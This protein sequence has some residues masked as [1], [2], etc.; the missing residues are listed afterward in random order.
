MAQTLAN[1]QIQIEAGD[2]LYD[3]YG[4][5]WRQLSGY[6]G[7]PTKLQIGTVLNSPTQ[8][9]NPVTPTTSSNGT[10]TPPKSNADI[11]KEIDAKNIELAIKQQQLLDNQTLDSMGITQST[12]DALGQQ[13]IA[14]MAAIGTAIQSQYEAGKTVPQI[15]TKEDLDRIFT[16]AQNDPIIDK[17]YKEQ[18]TLGKNDFLMA[19][20]YLKAGYEEER[21]L[22]ADKQTLEKETLANTEAESGRAYSGFRQQAESRLSA[23]QQGLIESTRRSSKYK[24]QGIGSA[25]EKQYGT[26]ALNQVNP[27]MNDIAYNPQ[28]NIAG[29]TEADRLDS[30]R[31]REQSIRSDTLLTRGLLK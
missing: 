8:S 14:T 3:I 24:M 11:Q 4:S 12:K 7:D 21:R 13:G 20:E 6:T 25:F 1:G 19:A 22:L 28:G 31:K 17:Y 23:N 5:N 15:L 18:L 10:A 26:Q 16:E 29:Q 2:R 9:I 27:S 30:I